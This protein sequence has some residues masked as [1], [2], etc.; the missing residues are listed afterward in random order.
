MPGRRA[1]THCSR[2]VLDLGQGEDWVRARRRAQRAPTPEL[3]QD[4]RRHILGR[5]RVRLRLRGQT[6][7]CCSESDQGTAETHH[8]AIPE[9][10][11]ATVLRALVGGGGDASLSVP[12][13]KLAFDAKRRKRLKKR[14]KRS[15]AAYQDARA[16]ASR[17]SLFGTSQSFTE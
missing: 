16:G 5:R 9:L 12:T 7:V 14:N 1:A 10:L 3:R 17:L 15:T 6:T 13:E 2:K 4:P 8:A 11:P